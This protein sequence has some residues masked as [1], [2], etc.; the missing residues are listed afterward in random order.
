MEISDDYGIEFGVEE[1]ELETEQTHLIPQ[2]QHQQINEHQ[3]R[4]NPFDYLSDDSIITLTKYLPTEDL[5]SFQQSSRRFWYICERDEVWITYVYNH[6]GA[7]LHSKQDAIRKM[8]VKQKEDNK[9]EVE[10]TKR[11]KQNEKQQQH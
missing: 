2:E 8:M 9:R 3:H 7:R 5:I 11:K 10:T 6:T 1:V 4:I